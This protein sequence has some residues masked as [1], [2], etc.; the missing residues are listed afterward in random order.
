MQTPSQDPRG[1]LSRNGAAVRCRSRPAILLLI[2]FIQLFSVPA[3]NLAGILH[4]SGALPHHRIIHSHHRIRLRGGGDGEGKEESEG[5]DFSVGEPDFSLGGEQTAP[6]PAEQPGTTVDDDDFSIGTFEDFAPAKGEDKK[7]AIDGAG[8]QGVSEEVASPTKLRICNANL[9]NHADFVA[10][11][12]KTWIWMCSEMWRRS[13]M[14]IST[15]SKFAAPS[16]WA[17]QN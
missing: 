13:T 17:I 9:G 6:E 12:M 15:R 3:T 1:F 11:R 10:A 2:L 5:G 7:G 14:R 8:S 4:N 16:R